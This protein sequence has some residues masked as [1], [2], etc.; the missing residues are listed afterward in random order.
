M[1]EM[2][3][4]MFMGGLESAI[5]LPVADITTVAYET[6]TSTR[7]V[8][9]I[10]ATAAVQKPAQTPIQAPASPAIITSQQADSVI[11]EAVK[12]ANEIKIPSNIAVTDPYGHLVSFLRMDGAVLVSIDVAIKK[13]KTVSMFNG[14]Y[15]TADLFNTTSPGGSLYGKQLRSYF[16]CML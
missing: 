16:P 15:R 4:N 13:A 9:P 2:S 11:Q 12:K 7:R 10:N 14:R 1:A 3:E 8:L 6:S 5:S